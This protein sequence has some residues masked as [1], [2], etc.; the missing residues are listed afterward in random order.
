MRK[1]AWTSWRRTS[2]RH[3]RWLNFVLSAVVRSSW[4]IA[5]LEG[6]GACPK[7]APGARGAVEDVIAVCIEKGRL[8]GSRLPCQVRADLTLKDASGGTVLH[9]AA[10]MGHIDIATWQ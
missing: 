10:L 3:G 6:P 2:E 5:S 8:A 9:A 4:A 7:G 1:T